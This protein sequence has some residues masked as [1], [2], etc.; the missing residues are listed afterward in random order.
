MLTGEHSRSGVSVAPGPAVM[1]A[2]RAGGTVACTGSTRIRRA[3]PERSCTSGT[4]APLGGNHAGSNRTTCCAGWSR[5]GTAPAFNSTRGRRPSVTI[6]PSSTPLEHGPDVKASR[7][8]RSAGAK[9]DFPRSVNDPDAPFVLRHRV[10]RVRAPQE[11]TLRLRRWVQGRRA[12]DGVKTL[13]SRGLAGDG[14]VR[15]RT[16]R[17]D[18]PLDLSL[19]STTPRG[20]PLRNHLLRRRGRDLRSL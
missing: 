12:A 20:G 5:S 2:L 18:M 10:D 6:G 16:L 14:H 3:A 1:A 4:R 19:P 7:Q 17:R 11:R 15:G 13:G 8:A 9:V